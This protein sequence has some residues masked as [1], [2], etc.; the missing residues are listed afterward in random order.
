LKII[1][2]ESS[3]ALVAPKIDRTRWPFRQIFLASAVVDPDIKGPTQ[4]TATIV[5]KMF[6]IEED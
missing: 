3:T 1:P 5:N 6:S 4:R 2:Q